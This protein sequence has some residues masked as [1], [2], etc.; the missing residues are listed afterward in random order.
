[1]QSYQIWHDKTWRG[2]D[3]FV[4]VRAANHRAE[5][6]GS[7]LC[8]SIYH[9]TFW[10]RTTK[11]GIVTHQGEGR[12]RFCRSTHRLG[13]DRHV[14]GYFVVMCITECSSIWD[15]VE[16]QM[17]YVCPD[18]GKVMTEVIHTEIHVVLFIVDAT[19]I[20]LTAVDCS[21]CH[22]L[23]CSVLY[24]LSWLL[25]VWV[26]DVLRHYTHGD[27]VCCCVCVCVCDLQSLVC[28]IALSVSEVS[29]RAVRWHV[30][31]W[32][33]DCFKC[34]SVVSHLCDHCVV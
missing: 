12:W 22:G 25:T 24:P 29:S 28:Y 31:S 4:R 6:P 32:Y 14:E 18:S 21:E 19:F 13:H 3:S 33:W 27:W 34:S 17:R 11:V 9:Y 8:N 2:E 15:L 1:M 23:D 20:M 16:Y 26:S 30:L 10:H 5:P 7:N